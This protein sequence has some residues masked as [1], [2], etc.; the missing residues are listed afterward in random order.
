VA[1]AMV[2]AGASGVVRTLTPL[3]GRCKNT[4]P[5]GHSRYIGLAKILSGQHVVSSILDLF[6]SKS[7]AQR[8]FNTRMQ[9]ERWSSFG[10]PWR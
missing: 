5:R 4:G 10:Q 3:H 9:Q 7:G 1:A 6:R 8:L 2:P